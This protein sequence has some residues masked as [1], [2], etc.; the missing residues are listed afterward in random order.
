[1]CI[2]LNRKEQNNRR[3][4]FYRQILLKTQQWTGRDRVV[5]IVNV[6]QWKVYMWLRALLCKRGR[7]DIIQT[8]N[9]AAG[10]GNKRSNHVFRRFTTGSRSPIITIIILHPSLICPDALRQIVS[11][12]VWLVREEAKGCFMMSNTWPVNINERAWVWGW[13]QLGYCSDKEHL[14]IFWEL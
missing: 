12:K 14:S 13:G 9:I 1:M 4:K 7:L 11:G 8:L 5:A 10:P 6:E 3:G 2:K